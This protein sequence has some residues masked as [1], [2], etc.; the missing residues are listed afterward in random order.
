MQAAAPVAASAV[1]VRRSMLSP[2]SRRQFT[3]LWGALKANGA[4]ASMRGAPAAGMRPA[5]HGV[6]GVTVT[7]RLGW[8]MH[9]PGALGLHRSNSERAGAAFG[10]L[11]CA[12]LLGAGQPCWRARAAPVSAQAGALTWQLRAIDVVCLRA[13]C[14]VRALGGRGAYAGAACLQ[15]R[16][17]AGQRVQ[18]L[19]HAGCR[20]SQIRGDM[21]SLCLHS[22]DRTSL[23]R[24][25][26]ARAAAVV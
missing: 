2:R 21:L 13:T 9:G 3:R 18:C 20:R 6:P 24:G 15:M 25:E 8:C 4:A 10:W 7:G 12:R 23:E 14:A 1:S 16:H 5:W 11:R 26:A 19:L 17:L 22:D